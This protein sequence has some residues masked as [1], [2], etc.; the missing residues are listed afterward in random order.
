[1]R[2]SARVSKC[3]HTLG[4]WFTPEAVADLA[5]T[6]ALQ[7]AEG[8]S[9]SEPARI[10]DP[11]CGDGVFLRRAV[12]RGI[13]PSSLVGVDI[14]DSAIEAARR[15]VPEAQLV[16]GDFFDLELSQG[17]EVIVGNPPYVRQERLSASAKER[18]VNTLS[19][20]WP[21]LDRGALASLVGRG[22]LAAPFMLHALRHLQPG[23]R[24]ALV[25]SSAFLDSGYGKQFWGLLN[26]VASLSLLVEAPQERWFQDAAVHTLIA[27]FERRQPSESL[28]LARLSVPTADA[29]TEL[30]DGARLEDLADLRYA[31]SDKPATWA[32]ALRAP[33]AWLDF[34]SQAADALTTLGEIAEIRRGVTT[35]ANEFFYL[36][37]E[38]A[39][40]LQL[41][42]RFLLPLLRAPGKTGQGC[43][44]VDRELGKEQVLAIPPDTELSEYPGL[45][46]Y[47]ESFESGSLNSTL[48]NREPWWSLHL[49]PAQVFLSKAYAERFVQPY[50]ARPIVAD[51]RVYCVH[52][53]EGIEAAVLAAVLNAT[54]TALAL[55][56]L[57]RASMGQG[58]LEWTVGDAKNLPVVDPRRI[59]D[60]GPILQAFASLSRRSIE[61][62]AL[63]AQQEDRRRLDLA[64]LGRE[65]RPFIEPLHRA[66]VSCV[67]ARQ[68]RARA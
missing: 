29:A 46:A 30:A 60:T 37:S 6:L 22:D 68:S 35:G 44:A 8:R 13:A 17:V 33:A 7:G 2:Y 51:Q 64:L 45:S 16:C 63:E 20:A 38:Q 55:E 36:S 53:K 3:Q 67:E 65:L 23:G 25:I 28:C 1:M 34:E 31:A 66:L 10:M 18:M 59:A 41:P 39:Q 9:T 4:Q 52:P 43:I 26:Q 47:L 24:A 14:D 62:V 19:A 12:A 15:E 27:L 5:L 40:A 42:S 61:K 58:A 48:A 49:R 57:G 50:C 21:T 56:S 54:S 32:R 11:S